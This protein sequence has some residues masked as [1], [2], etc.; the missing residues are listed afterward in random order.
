MRL[1]KKQ[2]SSFDKAI[3]D[4]EVEEKSTGSLNVGVGY[5]TDGGLLLD[6]T[7]RER[8]L[9]GLG[10]QLAL[11]TTLA[12][13][14]TMFNLSFTE[15]YFRGRDVA[16]G[17]D[18]FHTEKDLQSISAHDS[19]STGFGLR[20]SFPLSE[21]LR[22]SWKY[23]LNHTTIK[24]VPDSASTLIKQQ[25]GS[26]LASNVVH[27]L[28]YDTRDS[29]IMPTKGAVTRLSNDLAGIGGDVFYLKNNVSIAQFYSPADRWVFSAS[30]RIGHILGL[31]EDVE[32]TDRFFLGGGSLRGFKNAGVGPRDKVSLDSLGGEFIYNGS[33]QMTM[34]LGLPDELGIMGRVFS[35]F[36]SLMEI[37]PSNS[38]VFDSSSLR[39]S[40]GGGIGWSS[41][42]GPINL[43][44]GFPILKESLDE[45]ETFR[46][47]FGTRF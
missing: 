43:D 44:F 34:P 21:R 40:V 27:G 36:G 12:T 28:T 47:N 25:K 31:G 26:R 38:N 5:G 18:I 41:P 29:K 17:F 4:V 42:F 8:N 24:N 32:I 2:G 15:P 37:S 33:A 7:M 22:Q 1:K 23:G 45:K 9:L 6:V 19:K 35:D 13:R 3:I 10:Q 14:K 16:A 39:A 46:V 11:A 30:G 20:T